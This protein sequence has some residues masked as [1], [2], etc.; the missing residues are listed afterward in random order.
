MPPDQP[1]QLEHATECF[2][3]RQPFLEG[4]PFLP[5]LA[6]RAQGRQRQRSTITVAAHFACFVDII[7]RRAG[8]RGNGQDDFAEAVGAAVSEMLR[9]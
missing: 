9:R 4:D 7:A 6:W 2:L 5:F 1:D 8:G 3:C